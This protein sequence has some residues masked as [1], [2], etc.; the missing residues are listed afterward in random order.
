MNHFLLPKETS[1]TSKELFF[2]ANLM[3]SLINSLMK[4][5]ASKRDLKAK[6]FGGANVIVEGSTVGQR[7]S[8]FARSF[9]HDEGIECV[10]ESLGGARA[11]RIRFWPTT[12]RVSQLRLSPTDLRVELLSLPRP[13]PPVVRRHD[14]ELW[15]G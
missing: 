15:N 9:L 10:S 11:R 4:L 6:L 2:G 7:N 13:A 3:E 12:G 5:G 1:G 14:A 8:Q